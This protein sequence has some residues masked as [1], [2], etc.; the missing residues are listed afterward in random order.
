MRDVMPFHS[1]V[2]PRAVEYM[3]ALLLPEAVE[4]AR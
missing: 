1:R 3:G 2:E 4:N